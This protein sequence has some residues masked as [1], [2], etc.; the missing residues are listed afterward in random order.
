VTF[1]AAASLARKCTALLVLIQIL[2]AG[3][4]ATL[5]SSVP[6][7]AAVSISSHATGGDGSYHDEL[8]CTLCQFAS[9][10]A[11]TAP[12]IAALPGTELHENLS[13][14]QSIQRSAQQSILRP[15]SRAPPLSLS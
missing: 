10:Q 11:K 14:A 7:N 4:A 2:A 1:Q 5:H 12:P 13:P 15:S 3:L 8:R 9:Q 6:S